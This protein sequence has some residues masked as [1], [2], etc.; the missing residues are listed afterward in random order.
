MSA[1]EEDIEESRLSSSEENDPKTTSRYQEVGVR[2]ADIS[3]SSFY[4]QL[5]TSAAIKTQLKE[6]SQ[7][8]LSSNLFRLSILPLRH[9]HG[10]SPSS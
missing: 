6:T 5:K 4:L 3:K 2:L 1:P 9:R 8:Q 7:G 10:V